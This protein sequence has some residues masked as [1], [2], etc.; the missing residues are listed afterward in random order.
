MT[1]A[2]NEE[3]LREIVSRPYRKVISGDDIEG[4]LAEAPELPGCVTAGETVQEALDMLRD[5][6]EGWI[7]DAL[8]AGEPIPEPAAALA[9]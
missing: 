9:T 4:Y 6:M 5:A 8:L 2:R 1:D 3:L 7:E